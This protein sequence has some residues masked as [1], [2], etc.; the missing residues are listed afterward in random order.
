LNDRAIEK[1]D[2]Y[3]ELEASLEEKA[4]RKLSLKIV[5]L[6]ARWK[7]VRTICLP[8]NQPFQGQSL[9]MTHASLF[10]PLES[11]DNLDDLIVHRQN[12]FF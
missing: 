11:D 3:I 9:V 7:V 5:H 12:D 1:G 4:L 8:R 6:I 2:E 10:A